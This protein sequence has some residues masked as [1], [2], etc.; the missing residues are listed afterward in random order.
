MLNRTAIPFERNAVDAG[1]LYQYLRKL[2]KLLAYYPLRESSGNAINYAPL[3]H[4]TLA[5]TVTGASQGIVG[6]TDYAYH[7]DGINDTVTF[8]VSIP[9]DK[10]TIGFL[11][12][13]RGRQTAN[14]RVLDWAAGGP[15]GGF[16]IL[17]PTANVNKLQLDIRNVSSLVASISSDVEV[18]DN[19]IYF[20]C[21][22]YQVN[23]AKFYIDGTLQG[24][25][26][27]SVTLSNPSQT[28]TMM[29]RSSG[30]TNYTMG[31]CSDLF[32][33]NDVLTQST[34]SEINT[35][36]A[37]GS[38]SAPKMETLVDNFNFGGVD[39]FKWSN[40]GSPQTTAGE[41][42]RL[43]LTSTT[44]GGY[45]GIDSYEFYDLT[46]SYAYCELVDAGDQA[47]E[48]FEL[49][50]IHLS[51]DADNSISIRITENVVAAR[52]KIA[53]SSST[54]GD[55]VVYNATTMKWFRI[56][57]SAGTTY[58]EYAALSAGPWTEIASASN[59]LTATRLKGGVSIGTWQVEATTSTAVV[60]N[61][62]TVS[63]NEYRFAWKGLNWFKRIH[64]GEPSPIQR[65][66]PNNIAVNSDGYLVLSLTNTNNF[67]VGCE[68]YSEQRGFGYGTYTI[69]V[70]SQL[71]TLHPN[72]AFGGLYTFDFPN[73]PDWHEIDMNEVRTYDGEPNK[74][75]LKNHVW[76]NGGTREFTTTNMD[77]SSE[78]IQTHRTIWTLNSIV[79]DSF[80]GE[81]VGGTNYFHAEHTS[82]VP[83][84]DTER[85]HINIWTDRDT[86]ISSSGAVHATPKDV[87]VRSVTFTAA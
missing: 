32:I 81:G 5:G 43:E 83:V 59:P 10:L 13:R 49:Y 74:Q 76:N 35:I 7:F 24:A 73:P 34:I 80:I 12:R 44:G 68:V 1:N 53:T 61:F 31:D 56:R 77:I 54:I 86:A 37:F 75:L 9:T 18:L 21:F 45:Y 26:D 64:Q 25:E 22:T 11:Y 71:N 79:F 14:D 27:T 82:N 84:P 47:L 30:A 20:I 66:S 40:W 6:Q 72:V 85:L 48:S 65:W 67:P 8:P 52:K 50:P 78:I 41:N 70:A 57:E 33:V 23:S 3:T 62:N 60:K 17:H 69:V 19:Q 4:G 58:W 15:S 46:S 87:I 39:G 36:C 28:L 51:T 38:K 16:E 2:P 63:D 42:L 55:T 29:K